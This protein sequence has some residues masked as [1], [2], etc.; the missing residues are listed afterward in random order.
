MNPT[1][2]H[3]LPG[4]S[5]RS[6]PHPPNLWTVPL[7]SVGA[8]IFRIRSLALRRQLSS[9]ARHEGG[10]FFSR[11]SGDPNFAVGDRKLVHEERLNGGPGVAALLALPECAHVPL[12]FEDAMANV[13][14]PSDTGGRLIAASKVNGTNVYNTG[15]M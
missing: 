4:G 6:R 1:G 11:G 2:L 10:L 15:I 3:A 7:G 13:D 5:Y 9:G 12:A 14:N 8:V